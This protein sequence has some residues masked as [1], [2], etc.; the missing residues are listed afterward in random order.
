MVTY[1]LYSAKQDLA[2]KFPNIAILPSK[3]TANVILFCKQ[4]FWLQLST[5]KTDFYIHYYFSPLVVDLG[6]HYINTHVLSTSFCE[7]HIVVL[8]LFVAMVR[9]ICGHHITKAARVQFSNGCTS[10]TRQATVC[11]QIYMLD[12]LLIALVQGL[13]HWLTK[14]EV[15]GSNSS[16]GRW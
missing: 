13:E 16:K 12:I 6:L 14:H 7:H 15:T 3:Q 4:Y 2:K 9:R 1:I 11:L 8:L 10:V 5:T